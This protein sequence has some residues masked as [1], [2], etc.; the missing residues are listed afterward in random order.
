MLKYKLKLVNQFGGSEKDIVTFYNKDEFNEFIGEKYQFNTNLRKLY[1]DNKKNWPVE[2]THRRNVRGDGNCFFRA[3]YFGL[4]LKILEESKKNEI[5]T[6]EM[7]KTKINNL[8]ET[9]IDNIKNDT[10]ESHPNTDT[11]KMLKTSAKTNVIKFFSDINNEADTEDKIIDILNKKVNIDGH[12]Y[13]ELDIQIIIIFRAII[14][15]WFDNKDNQNRNINEGLTLE[16][17]KQ[18]YSNTFDDIKQMGKDANELI[19]AFIPKIF[20]NL[21]FLQLSMGRTDGKN[22]VRLNIYSNKTIDDLSLEEKKKKMYTFGVSGGVGHYYIIYFKNIHSDIKKIDTLEPVK[23]EELTVNKL[24]EIL[25]IDDLEETKLQ[26]SVNTCKQIN[27]FEDFPKNLEKH[28]IYIG[29]Q[30]DNNLEIISQI[31]RGGDLSKLEKI[32]K[33]YSC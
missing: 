12:L 20:N 24:K 32:D 10:H 4:I 5:N 17:L 28:N 31:K 15:K 9:D 6:K 21:N 33:Y 3:F 30:K 1:N 27:K 18:I 14:N 25:S 23:S 2:I 19:F 16:L 11:F 7:L 22:F 26:K 8:E 29:F 13:N